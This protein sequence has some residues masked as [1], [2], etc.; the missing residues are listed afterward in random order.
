LSAKQIYDTKLIVIDGLPGSGKTT[1][2]EWL[3]GKFQREEMQIVFVSENDT[4]H[5]LWW[6]EYWN[7]DEYLTPDFDNIPI[8][9]FIET[10]LTKWRSFVDLIQQ[11]EQKVCI[12]SVFFQNAIGMF[13]MGGATPARLMEYALE[14]Q[15][16]A[17][18][19]NPVLIY[20][21]QNNVASALQR[22]CAIRGRDFESELLNN[23]ESFP[24]LRQRNLKGMT[25]VTE[26]WQ[27]IQILADHIY[28]EYNFQ[29][30]TLETSKGEWLDYR[31]QI[32]EFLDLSS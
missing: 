18:P 17:Y 2:A 23:M 4:K 30:L 29:K 9:S 10:S 6:Y 22:I 26:L 28:S 21:R 7:G 11:S 15:L 14:V 5:P 3:T 8:E 16:I 1:T 25:G 32:L 20:F 19:L 13:L 31:Q 12:E 24:Y 27:D